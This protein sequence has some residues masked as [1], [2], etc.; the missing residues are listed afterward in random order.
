MPFVLVENL[1]WDG[2][3]YSLSIAQ[4][5]NL[6][7]HIKE[8]DTLTF[9]ILEVRNEGGDLVKRFKPLTRMQKLTSRVFLGY[10]IGFSQLV[11]KFSEDE[12]N[13]LN[14]GNNYRLAILITELNN[15]SIFPFELRVG[16]YGAEEVVKSIGKIES[17][18]LY[19]TQPELQQTVNYLLEASV[20]YEEGRIEDARTN[21]R[22]SLEV[23]A[24]LREKVKPV[25]GREV[26]DFGRRLENLIRGIKGFVDYGG[27]HLG[28]KPRPTTEMVF[29][30]IVELVKM[31]SLNLAEKN[32]TLGDEE[33]E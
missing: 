16:G 29:N 6:A 15:K 19:V 14:I 2:N 4:L 11:L 28:P 24:K 8:G 1:Q 31:L 3:D 17:S 23:L 18:L 27:P 9:Y 30:V 32:I 26:E 5:Y 10:I 12:A 21:L 33:N 7:P 13:E 25:Q 20:L 22:K